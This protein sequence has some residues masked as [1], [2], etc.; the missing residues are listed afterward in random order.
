MALATNTSTG[1]IKLAGDLNG[2]NDATAPELTLTGVVAGEY[3][4]PILTIDSKGRI[5]NVD[6]VDDTSLQPFLPEASSTIKGV[7]QINESNGLSV[8]GG[9]LSFSS[10]VDP[11]DDA[12]TT[13]KGIVQIDET[14]GL[15]INAG[16]LGIDF[17]TN[18]TFGTVKSANTSHI[19][20]V[21]G[22]VDVGSG[23]AL[24]N[25]DNVFTKT[26][27]V[28]INTLTYNVNITPDGAVSN[29]MEVTLTGNTT[30]ENPTN[31]IAGAFYSVQIT[32]DATGSRTMAYGTAF[33]F[34][35]GVVPILSTAANSIDIL[36]CISDG[37]NLYST[38][39]K[40]LS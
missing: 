23:V 12:T 5:T 27:S 14:N 25:Q 11:I 18:T 10:T 37:T 29:V 26:Q 6:D 24:N 33:K 8:T 17:G 35:G 31:L 22:M 7:V 20:I 28:T 9:V 19:T 13:S 15:S 40:D 36:T 16:V 34:K 4:I 30:L 1:T 39:T 38:L 32:Q 3:L 21:D 2:N